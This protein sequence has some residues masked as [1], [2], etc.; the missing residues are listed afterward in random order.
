VATDPKSVVMGAFILLICV[1]AYKKEVDEL[2]DK[3]QNIN[4][5]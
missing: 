1:A 2:L 3:C 5:K 4:R